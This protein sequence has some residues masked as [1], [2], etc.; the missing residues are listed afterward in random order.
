MEDYV[1]E[2]EEITLQLVSKL[3]HVTYEEL[4]DF[5]EFR[6]PI[7]DQINQIVLK[8]E[9]TFYEKERLQ[10]LLQYDSIIMVRMTV[11]KNEA[12]NWLTQRKQ[13]TRQRSVYE[14]T[15]TPDS[16]LMDKRK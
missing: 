14:A 9:L 8:R 5:V 15:F 1:G 16:F 6:Q 10:A 7:V 12:G 13:A 4:A 2:L 3:E 11:L